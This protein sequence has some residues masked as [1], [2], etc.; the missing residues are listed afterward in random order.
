MITV[1]ACTWIMLW[2][3]G[4]GLLPLNWKI[5]KHMQL[6]SLRNFFVF[7]I[8]KLHNYA[9]ETIGLIC[10]LS[11]IYDPWSSCMVLHVIVYVHAFLLVKARNSWREAYMSSSEQNLQI[12]WPTSKLP[13]STELK[14]C[15]LAFI[16]RCLCTLNQYILCGDL[17]ILLL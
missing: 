6:T 9:T 15:L 13:T 4:K 10:I 14:S 1:S 16:K 5:H 12:F 3:R 11:I 8:N 7:H 2:R 17:Y